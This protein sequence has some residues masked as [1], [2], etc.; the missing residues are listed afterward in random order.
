MQN[1]EAR[2]RRVIQLR[3]GQLDLL[4]LAQNLDAEVLNGFLVAGLVRVQAELAVHLPPGDPLWGADREGAV[5]QPQIEIQ[6]QRTSF[7]GG[8]DAML[9]LDVGMITA[10]VTFEGAAFDD[11]FTDAATIFEIRPA[12]CTLLFPYAAR[13]PGMAWN[14]GITVMNPGY[15]E[16]GVAGGLELTFY[17]N[18]GTAAPFSTEEYPTVGAGLDEMGLVPAGGT[19]TVLASEVLEATDWGESFVGHIHVLADYTG[20]NGVGWVTDFG[21]VNQAYVAVV[22]DSDTGKD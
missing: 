1:Q 9:P 18:D 11:A 5:H 19:Y 20:C 2:S 21:T 22:I 17:G 14:T 16:G 12:Q 3:P 10:R 7:E 6:A 4:Q 15:T 8:D 13:L